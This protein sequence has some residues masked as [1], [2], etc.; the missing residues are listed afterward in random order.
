MADKDEK[1]EPQTIDPAEYESLKA[2]VEQLKG[3]NS[4]YE[5]LLLDPSYIEFIAS[6]GQPAARQVV[7][8]QAASDGV[9]L[10]S[11]TQKE[12]AEYLVRTFEGMLNAR[13]QP[14]TQEMQFT[15][16]Q[17]Q[18]R[19]VSGKY[20]DFW[21]FKDDMIKLARQNPTLSAEDTYHIAKGRGNEKPK[22]PTRRSE[23]PTGGGGK[24]VRKAPEGFEAKFAEA[25]AKSGLGASKEE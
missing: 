19:E 23:P 5:R 15:E 6:R 25:W 1:E 12:L 2:V 22:V 8:Q 24:T 7:Q 18:V 3:K 11:M 10:D 16:M 14:V 9:D 13:V 21:D 17:R 20:S 4:E